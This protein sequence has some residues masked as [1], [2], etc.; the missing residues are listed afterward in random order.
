MRRAPFWLRNPVRGTRQILALVLTALLVWGSVSRAASVTPRGVQCPTAAVQSVVVAQR[1]CCGRIVGYEVRKPK[2]G[3]R[4]F[5]QCRC[6]EKRN[7]THS[8]DA[9]SVP[10]FH[11]IPSSFPSLTI[12]A[13]PPL[14]RVTHFY[15]AL[16]ADWRSAPP[17]R[18]PVLS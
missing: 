15:A 9:T 14:P 2:E 11:A 16:W 1:D 4:D 8:V 7:A 12:P 3:E 6:A 10:S 18:P 13:A 5:L 17:T